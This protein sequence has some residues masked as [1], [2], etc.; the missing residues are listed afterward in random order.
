MS[1]V[2]L[3]ETIRE[4]AKAWAAVP[5]FQRFAS[6]LPRNAPQPTSGLPG[7]LQQIQAG[8]PFFGSR[9]LLHASHIPMMLHVIPGLDPGILGTTWTSWLDDARSVET[10]HRDTVAWVRSR[11]RGYPLL[12]AP[13]LSPG[14]P[15]TTN[16]FTWRLIW[17]PGERSRQLQF[18]PAPP[19]ASLAL[20]AT[21]VERRR[22]D[23][24]ARAVVAAFEDTD[25]WAHLAA[26]TEA[27]D[28]DA[29]ASLRSVRATLQQRLTAQAVDDH[30]PSLAMHRDSYRRVVLSEEIE[31]LSGS[32]REYTDAFDAADQ[33]VEKAA[34]TVFGQLAAHGEPTRHVRPQDVELLPHRAVTFTL[35]DNVLPPEIG[36]VAWI[37]DPLIPDAVHI[38]AYNMSYERATGVAVSVSGSVLTGTA[39][40]WGRLV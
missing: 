31:T 26:A 27:L 12:P 17:T 7:L 8:D 35:T 3:W 1:H 10:A 40:A 32:A 23:N 18:Q 34:S 28:G 9:L 13:Q 30:E 22:L 29:R 4:Q 2:P 21:E 15:L 24:C 33:L 14:T 39:T 38:N 16:K 11:L 25:E 37:D 5:I 6:Q 36:S 19:Q 20:Q